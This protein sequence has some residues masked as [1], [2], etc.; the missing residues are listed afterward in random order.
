MPAVGKTYWGKQ[1]AEQYHFQFIDLDAFIAEQETASIPAL[2]AQ[3]GEAGFRERENIFLQKI[4]S[5][6]GGNY[7]VACGGG[8]PC[9][10]NNITLMKEAGIVI[11]LSSSVELLLHNLKDSVAT[12]PLL[13]GQHDTAAYLH[14]LLEER[15]AVY[16]QAHIILQT[17]DISITTFG[18]IISSCT[19]RQ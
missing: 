1:I 6:S 5:S 17:E 3:Y 10:H 2:F 15:R 16:E 9:F 4:I 13:N 18:K 8:T 7:V 19:D 11:Y 14:K 12:R